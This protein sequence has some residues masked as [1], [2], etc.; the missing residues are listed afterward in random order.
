MNENIRNIVIFRT[1]RIGEVLLSTVAVDA[2]KYRYPQARVTF[3]TSEYSRGIVDGRDDIDEV[4]TAGTMEK[5]GWFK[6]A[7]RLSALLEKK[8]FDVSLVLNPHKILHLACFLAGIPRRL[9]Y[10]RKWGFFLNEKIPDQRERGE[11]HEIEYTM[12][13][14]RLLGIEGK[15]PAP[16]LQVNSEAGKVIEKLLSAKGIAAD[17]PLICVHPGSS[18]PAKVWPHERYAELIRRLKEEAGCDVAVLGG[19]EETGLTGKILTEAGTDALDFAGMLDLK[20]LAALIKRSEL[21]IG[22]DTGTMHM[23]AAL[24]VPVIAIFGRNIP[25]VSPARWRPWGDKHVVFHEDPG[26]DPC[27][28][29]ACPYDYKCLRAITVEAVFNAAKKIVKGGTGSVAGV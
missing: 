4:L 11:K 21:F 29:T 23:A 3:V 18:N 28:D 10:D 26:C 19:K 17:M 6:K 22:N 5:G 15:A 24:D 16:R 13:L 14:L 12:D 7:V 20:E 1:D 27:Y 25:G 8:R 9:G 2:V